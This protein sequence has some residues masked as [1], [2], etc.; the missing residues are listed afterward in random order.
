MIFRIKAFLAYWFDKKDQ[1]SLHSPFLYDFYVNALISRLGVE[2]KN[3]EKLRSQFLKE[4][5][6]LKG[7][8]MGAGTVVLNP[9][10]ISS[11]VRNGI[12][13]KSRSKLLCRIIEYFEY[14]NVLELGTSVGLNAAYL[15]SPTCV[16]SVTSVEGNGEIF[17]K[18][19]EVKSKLELDNLT[20]V[21]KDI[22]EF[23]IDCLSQK[24]QFDFIYVDANHT[25]EATLNYFTQLKQLWV[26]GSVMIF[27]DIHWS[28]EMH[29]AWKEIVRNCGESLVIERFN[30]GM[31]FHPNVEAS[32][33]YVLDFK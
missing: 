33:H 29:R 10:T 25:Y 23:L 13:T 16:K 7:N 15:A 19:H 9:R 1:H 30:L 6:I 3:I 2:N 12:S 20:L 22:D 31:V 26:S 4:E 27:D 24:A 18:A 28:V 11:I 5:T 21:H 8:G 17:E 32:G 14:S